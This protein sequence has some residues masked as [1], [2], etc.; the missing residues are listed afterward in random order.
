MASI[1]IMDSSESAYLEYIQQYLLENDSIIFTNDLK[2]DDSKSC[3]A[4]SNP[5]CDSISDTTS[6]SESPTGASAGREVHAPPTWKRYRGVRRRPWGKF[7][8]EIRDPKKN[9][10]RVWLGT[11]E[12]EE[13]AAIAYDKAAFK[14]RGRKAK[15]NFPHLIGSDEKSVSSSELSSE[16]VIVSAVKRIS[17]EP[18]LPSSPSSE[19]DSNSPGSKRRRN[20][21]DLLNKIAKNRNQTN[22]VVK[23][24][25]E[26]NVADYWLNDE[27]NMILV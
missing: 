20:L 14:M 8:A 10:A 17:P 5:N 9:G 25:P 19:D 6:H 2:M 22:K 24:D 11:Y 12:T 1:T 15:L 16:P 3:Q 18:C 27:F 26:A 13:K 23:M 21:A 4:G 7:A